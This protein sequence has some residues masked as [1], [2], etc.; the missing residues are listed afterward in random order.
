MIKPIEMAHKMLSQTVKTGDIVIDAT[1]GNGWDTVFLA[2]LTNN[3]Y[4]FDI[5]KE[6]IKSTEAMLSEKRLQAHLILDGHENIDKYVTQPVKAAIFNLGYLPR[7]DKSII[8]RPETTLK[9]L[10]ILKKKLLPQGQIMI[11]IYYGHEGGQVEKDTVVS[12]ASALPQ[13]EWHVMKYE[14]MN[15]IHNPPFLICIEKR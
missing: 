10:E 2:E 11:V 6:A 13:A 12:W 1:M 15:Q 9:A 5:Q 8:T 3:V 7:T 4:A 14:P